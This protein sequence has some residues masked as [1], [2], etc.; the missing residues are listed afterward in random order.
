M[1]NDLAGKRIAVTGSRKIREL[2][3]IIERYG[4]EALFRPQQELLVLQEQ[5]VEQDLEL[6]WNK[7][8]ELEFGSGC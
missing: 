5:E 3:E 4:G 2:S 1:A 7:Q 6:Y 8:K